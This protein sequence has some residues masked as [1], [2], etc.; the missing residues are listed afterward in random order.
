MPELLQRNAIGVSDVDDRLGLPIRSSPG[1]L[2]VRPKRHR[3]QD[4][5]CLNRV[6]ECLGNDARADRSRLRFD[7]IGATCGRD[8]GLDAFSGEHLGQGLADGAEAD[9]CIF[10]V[11][12]PIVV[13]G[14]LNGAYASRPGLAISKQRGASADHSS[15]PRSVA[16]RGADQRILPKV[17]GPKR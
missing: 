1:G 14:A 5:I 6:L 7:R 2:R 9:N 11:Q 16:Y 15:Q 12:R 13:L 10:H 8:D 17:C 4:D 3:K